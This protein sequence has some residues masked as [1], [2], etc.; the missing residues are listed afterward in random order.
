MR[1]IALVGISFLLCQC[2][3]VVSGKIVNPDGSSLS[4]LEGKVNISSLDNKGLT[5]V[6]VVDENGEFETEDDIVPGEYLVEPLIP[7]TKALP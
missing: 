7:D 5:Q 3:T 2:R 6:V 4:K 1:I